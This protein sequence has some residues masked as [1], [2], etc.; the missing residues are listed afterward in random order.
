MSFLFEIK[1]F[2]KRDNGAERCSMRSQPSC[3]SA[4]SPGL[5]TFL[6]LMQLYIWLTNSKA[7]Q[8]GQLYLHHK[9]VILLCGSRN[10][11]FMGSGSFWI[12]RTG[13]KHLITLF[14]REDS[15]IFHLGPL[16]PTS[17]APEWTWTLFPMLL[18]YQAMSL[19]ISQTI[20]TWALF[21]LASPTLALSPTTFI[22]SFLFHFLKVK[23]SF[24]SVDCLEVWGQIWCI[25]GF[26]PCLSPWQTPSVALCRSFQLSPLLLSH[27]LK[28]G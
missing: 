22:L 26:W 16:L 8:Q 5:V 4:F 23:L 17:G 19:P 12:H 21:F 3:L 2:V 28:S 13:K 1:L 15:L 6:I 18:R 11:L 25:Q 20:S 7:L 9:L 27:L 24:Q 10:H 14:L